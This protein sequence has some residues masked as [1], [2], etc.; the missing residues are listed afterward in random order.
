MAEVVKTVLVPYSP[1]QMFDLVDGVER[2]P[3]FLPWCGATRLLHRDADI[4]RATLTIAFKGVK[5]SFTTENPKTIPT[6]MDIRLVEG[7]FRRLDGSWRFTDLG[8]QGCRIEFR[9]S[10]ELASRI[11]DKLIGPVFGHIANTLVEAFIRRAEQVY[12]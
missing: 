3:E 9:L 11:L 10:Y 12:G 2:Y 8:G 6:A 1:Q 4:T 5:Q 7:P